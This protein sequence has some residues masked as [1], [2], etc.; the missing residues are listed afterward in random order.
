MGI[1]MIPNEI[2]RCKKIVPLLAN[3]FQLCFYTGFVPQQWCKSIIHPIHKS[4]ET[5]P[6]IPTHYRGISLVSCIAK[7][8]TGMLAHRVSEFAE[9]EH[10]F[11]EE[12]GGFRKGRS[13][14]DQI[15]ILNSVIKQTLSKDKELFTCFIDLRKAFDCVNRN[16]LLYKLLNYGINGKLFKVLK[17]LYDVQKTMASI[18]VNDRLSDWFLTS[19]GVKQGDSLSPVLFIL[20]INDL[21]Q[22]LINMNVGVKINDKKMPI[23]LYA[24]DI[25][26]I[27]EDKLEL[28]TMLDHVHTW[29][30]KWLMAV[31]LDKTKIVHF[32]KKRKPRSNYAFKYGDI[33][34][35]YTNVYKYLGVFF[36]EFNDFEFNAE[37]LSKAGGRA[38]GGII[39]KLKVNEVLS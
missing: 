37:Q 1:D 26:L 21:A 16:M 30:K 23:L 31:N 18:R 20:F 9:S 3:L 2:L 8:F 32:R 15:F 12:Q 29:C 38:L 24:D 14:T 25:V 35:K 28:Q 7:V 34:V 19:Q 33:D 13:C 27:S 36:D 11:A 6:R 39:S 17:S 5:D 4:S 10:V 22:E